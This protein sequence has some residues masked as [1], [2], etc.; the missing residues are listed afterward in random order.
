[1]LIRRVPRVA[2]PP[3]P[4][5][6]SVIWPDAR[7]TVSLEDVSA[8]RTIKQ[9]VPAAHDH[10]PAIVRSPG[11]LPRLLE[12]V[13][14]FGA[15]FL[16]AAWPV[17]EPNEPHYLGK[18]K[19]YW[20]P[21][22]IEHD[23][24]LDSA[25]S[26]WVFYATTG[27]LSRW[28]PLPVFAWV[29]RVATWALLAFG[30]CRLSWALLPR[31]G[32][33]VLSALL[34]LA[35]NENF[36]MAGEWVVGGF[37]AK[38]LAY[39]LVFAALA[40]L[41][42]GRWNTT[43]ILLG[44][45]SALHVLVGGWS[46][47]AVGI[48]W[49]ASRADRPSLLSMAPGLAMGLMLSLPGLVPALRLTVGADPDVVREANRIYV[50][51]RLPHH[52]WFYGIK[53]QFRTRLCASDPGLAL[54]CAVHECSLRRESHPARR[55]CHAVD[56]RDWHRIELAGPISPGFSRGTVAVLLVSPG[57]RDDPVGYS[58]GGDDGRLSVRRSARCPLA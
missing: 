13:V 15:F 11:F 25:D 46:A 34:F 33:P 2:C 47:I 4:P 42:H 29:G 19:H 35:L 40:E 18:A 30:W 38:G 8:T 54:P 49:L 31:A 27:W 23:F 17:P 14:V 51:G 21:A 26:H 45:A 55:E 52:L 1:M 43:W 28:V 10:E 57:R 12:V 9:A 53:A 24:F 36:H 7:V 6:P 37:E 32:A 44:A 16:F 39:A 20:N 5:S 58:V 22:W 48:C 50:Y 56:G 41:A 3:V